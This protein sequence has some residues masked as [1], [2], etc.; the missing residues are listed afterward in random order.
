MVY[1]AYPPSFKNHGIIS[2]TNENF[3]LTP[4]LQ[5]F[6]KLKTRI[7]AHVMKQFSNKYLAGLY[8]IFL[9][10]TDNSCTNREFHICTVYYIHT[11][12]SS[13]SLYHTGYKPKNLDP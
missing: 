2:G 12:T 5:N 3:Q 9:Q 6:F 10:T 8:N 4:A 11:L 7:I 1:N 13:I